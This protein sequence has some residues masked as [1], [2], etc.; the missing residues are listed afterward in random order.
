MKKMI[1]NGYDSVNDGLEKVASPASR[2]GNTVERVGK[3]LDDGVSPKVIA[4]QMTENSFNSQEY[5][6]D[7]VATCGKI[8]KDAKIR[9][10]V[11]AKQARALSRDQKE[12]GTDS[13]EEEGLIPSY[14]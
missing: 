10:L 4:L 12:C 7:D 13:A 5:T 11:T 3:M 6:E 2:A 1:E 9:V 8:Y 14:S